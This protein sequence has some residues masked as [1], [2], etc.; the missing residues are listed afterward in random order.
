MSA[1]GHQMEQQFSAHSLSSRGSGRRQSS[2]VMDSGFY[3]SSFA[4]TI[5]VGA[6]VTV[7]VIL[8]TLLIA[9]TVMLQSC[10]SRSHGVIEIEKP[11]YDYNYCQIVSLHVE[12][13]KV[14]ADHFPS[15]CRVVALQY[16]KEGQYARDLNSTM[17]MI[18]NYFSS[19][20]PKRDGVDVVLMDI[21]DILS[22]NPQ[23]IKLLADRDDQY[24]SRDCVEEAKQLKHGFILRLYMKLHASRWPL[25]LLSRKPETQRNSSIEYLI[26][27]G[28]RAWSSLIMRFEDDLQMDSCDYFSKQRAAMQR[29]GLRIIGTISSHMDALT[30]TSLGERIF[31]LPNPIYYSF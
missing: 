31:K 14:E 27:A 22:S 3:M 10:Q 20:T 21:D 17:W 28:F 5:F 19:I 8:I 13:N 29:K 24:G 1:Y 26:S 11:S 6:L 25:I 2:Y 18:Q 16:I 9:L 30:G 4:S 15:I 7:G 23:Y 12:L